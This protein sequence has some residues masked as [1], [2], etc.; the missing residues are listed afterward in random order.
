MN[1]KITLFLLLDI[2]WKIPAIVLTPFFIAFASNET[3]SDK[4][5]SDLLGIKRA[6]YVDWLAWAETKDELMCGD[7]T[8]PFVRSIYDKFGWFCTA[9]YWLGVRNT[10]SILWYVGKPAPT[11]L[12][13][14][15]DAQKEE[16]GI[17]YKEIPL[18]LL[19]LHVGWNIYQDAYSKFTDNSFWATPYVS[20]RINAVFV[21]K[22]K[23][24]FSRKSA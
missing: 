13:I 7:L 16:Y 5:P 10:G 9:W 21:A 4:R 17:W 22:I 15:T 8:L 11:Y 6:K 23:S 19:E 20:I 24:I 3:I 14:I 2:L 12:A 18:L 1:L